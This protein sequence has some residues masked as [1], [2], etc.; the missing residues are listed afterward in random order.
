[1]PLTTKNWNY[2]EI[3]A[4]ILGGIVLMLVALYCWK[5]WRQSHYN[6]K[7]ERENR[8]RGQKKAPEEDANDDY[9][10]AD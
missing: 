9:Q 2:I 5:N 1:L 7:D 6:H 4:F 10:N 8:H 3:I